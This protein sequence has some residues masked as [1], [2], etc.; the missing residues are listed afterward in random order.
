MRIFALSDL[1]VDYDTNARCVEDLSTADY[2]NDV[3]IFASDVSDRLS[4]LSWCLHKLAKCLEQVLFV[5]GNHD[6]RVLHD[7]PGKTTLDKFREVAAVTSDSGVS[8]GPFHCDSLSIVPLLGW[9]DY[10][11]GALTGTLSAAWMDFVACRWPDGLQAPEISLQF[12]A[13]NRTQ[14]PK[15]VRR[16][17]TFSHFV[18]RIDL[19][20]GA[21]PAKHRMLFPVLG[22]THLD[23]QLRDLNSQMHVYGHSHINRRRLIDGVTYI[24]SAF[25]Y[26]H[27]ERIASKQ[28]TTI[29]DD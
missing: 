1:H 28:L 23:R 14:V 12:S 10:S 2:S 9:Y 6:L 19:L 18:S 4:M 5:P 26:P 22:S 21:L 29:L 7:A 13:L 24:N 16:V 15:G 17:I 27:E 11:F 8:I 20:P 25:G 3:L